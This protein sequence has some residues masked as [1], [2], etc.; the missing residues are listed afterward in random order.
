MEKMFEEQEK[1]EEKRIEE[2]IK[3]F[4]EPKTQLP[5][6]PFIPEPDQTIT[7]GM[8]PVIDPTSGLTRTQTALLLSLIHI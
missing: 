3:K 5:A 6:S 2:K 7:A 4:D 1:Y 8:A